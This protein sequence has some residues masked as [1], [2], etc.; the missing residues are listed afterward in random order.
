MLDDEDGFTLIE[1]LVVMIIIGILAAIAIPAFLNQ[2]VNAR[3]SAAKSDLRNLATLEEVHVD[4]Q[5]FY[6]LISQL[7]ANGEG[8]RASR[9]VTLS[10]VKYDGSN[11]YCLSA[12]SSASPN[13][14]FY[15]SSSF[16]MQPKGATGCPVT[17][18]GTNGDSIT[19]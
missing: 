10:V 7:Q 19:G 15:D 5:N 16:G 12:K 8:V 2:R 6:G 4:D 9:G 18:T 13:T 3:D 11:G 17:T 1:L 14:W